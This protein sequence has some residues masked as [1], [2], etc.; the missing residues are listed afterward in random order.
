MRFRFLALAGPAAARRRLAEQLACALGKDVVE[1]GETGLVSLWAD[2]HTPVI[3]DRTAS[4]VAIGMLF[5]R[6]ST[7]RL[8][9]LPDWPDLP[10]IITR[11]FWGP[12]V[13]ITSSGAS[14]TVTRDPSGAIPVYHAKAGDLH[15]YASDAGM[16]SPA[17]TGPLRPDLRAAT[18][19]LRYPYLRTARTGVTGVSELSPGASLEVTGESE[20]VRWRWSPETSVQPAVSISRFDDAAALLRSEILRCVPRLADTADDVVLQLSGGLDSSIIA[21]A[22]AHSGIAFRAITFATRSADGDERRYARKVADAFGVDLQEI[23]EDDLDWDSR[24]VPTPLQRPPNLILQPLRR[25]LIAA[26]DHAGLLLD[27]GGGDNLFA[28]INTAAPAIDAYRSVGLAKATAVLHDLSLLHGCTIWKAAAAALRRAAR[29]QAASWIAD[30]RFLAPAASEQTLE[31]HPWLAAIESSR[32]GKADHMRS[33]AGIFHFLPD[34]AAGEPCSLH[35]LIA[36]P[37]LELCLRIPAWLWVEGG[38]NR[39]VA[40]AAFRDLLPTDILDR[41]GKGSLQSLFVKAF[42]A[43]RP[44]LRDT[45]VAGRLA[46]EGIIDPH[47]V[48]AYLETVGDPHDLRYVRILDLAAT[49]QWLESFA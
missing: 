32:P 40:R 9:Q 21:A 33:V 27:G 2:S 37:L 13:L 44:K 1:Q 34:P 45:L 10:R 28:S 17:L 12:A 36:Q 26:G 35:P 18:H 5:D 8:E 7:R 42:K 6:S 3:H 49:E 23:S 43:E 25:A 46:A 41:R 38:R 14:H 19:W 20:T 30:D 29:P 4:A 16:L 47:A 39:A 48:S 15:V 24:S 31:P 11:D 22:L